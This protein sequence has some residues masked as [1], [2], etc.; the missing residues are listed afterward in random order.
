M[1]KRWTGAEGAVLGR[2]P[3]LGGLACPFASCVAV[4][5]HPSP[6]EG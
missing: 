4:L 2:A 6:G 3:N 5:A 1:V